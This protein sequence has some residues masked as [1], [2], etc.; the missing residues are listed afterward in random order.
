MSNILPRLQI[1]PAS[2]TLNFPST[3][4]DATVMK[5]RTQIESNVPSKLHR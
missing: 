3:P 4:D 1:W 5:Q 2:G